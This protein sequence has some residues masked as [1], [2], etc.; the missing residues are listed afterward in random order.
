MF[1][2]TYRPRTIG[3]LDNT[4]VSATL[5]NLLSAKTLPHALLFLGQKGM[6]KTSAA[7]I[8][9]KAVNCERNAFAKDSDSRTPQTIEPCNE[10]GTC[11]S[12]AGSSAPDVI[13]QDAASNRRIDEIRELIRESA[14]APMSARYRVFIIDEAHMI[15]NDAFNA[16]LKTL[17]E[18]PAHALFILATT[19]EEKIPKTIASRCVRVNFGNAPREDILHMLNRIATA[20]EIALPADTAGF[21]ADAS[22]L[23]FRDAT[24]MLE[25]LSIQNKLTLSEAQTYVGMRSRYSFLQQLE[26]GTVQESL[27]WVAQFHQ[28]GGNTK[29]LIED[30]LHTLEQF[31]LAKS[32]IPQEGVPETKLSI[33]DITRLMKLC[34]DAYGMLKISPQ[35]T[36]PLEIAV[37]EFYN[38]K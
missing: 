34:T 6:G 10:C 36:I 12:I 15:T 16:L 18:P 37:V 38:G 20:E 24:K 21:I 5:Q 13:E 4:R 30:V 32:G 33:K 19:N 14:F 1:Y 9:A 8:V 35:P 17:E 2:L 26:K 11:R 22:E 23:S 27:Q 29:L 3:E 25:E 28:T 31:L 7:R